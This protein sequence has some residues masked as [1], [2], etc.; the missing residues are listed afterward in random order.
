MVYFKLGHPS[1]AMIVHGSSWKDSTSLPQKG[2]KECHRPKGKRAI[3]VVAMVLHE[4]HILSSLC[5]SVTLDQSVKSIYFLFFFL[6][7]YKVSLS[8]P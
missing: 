2:S 3:V 8:A 6:S 7:F 5:T 4:T 1:F